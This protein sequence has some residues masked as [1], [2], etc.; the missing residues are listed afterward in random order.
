MVIAQ[1]RKI[2]AISRA[3]DCSW[4]S[5]GCWAAQD[6]LRGTRWRSS[7][8]LWTSQTTNT[9]AVE[10]SETVAGVLLDDLSAIHD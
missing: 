4:K 9:L 8:E 5:F 2:A 6:V 3:L 10:S 7:C 1:M